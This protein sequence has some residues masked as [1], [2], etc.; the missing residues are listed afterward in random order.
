M[1]ACS[2]DPRYAASWS[3]NT[4]LAFGP[5][6]WLNKTMPII[7]DKPVLVLA[8]ERDECF[9]Q[10][11]YRDAFKLVAP[12]AEIP[13]VGAGGHWDLLTEPK[14]IEALGAWLATQPDPGAHDPQHSER[15]S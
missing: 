2:H 3:F 15:A 13:S 8:G 1:D 11:L 10:P 5:G 6:R 7:D 4:R 14:A 12:H 9:V